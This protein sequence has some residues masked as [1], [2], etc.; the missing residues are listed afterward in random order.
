MRNKVNELKMGSTLFW[1]LSIGLKCSKSLRKS[2]SNYRQWLHKIGIGYPCH[3]CL[4]V[5]PKWISINSSSIFHLFIVFLSYFVPLFLYVCGFSITFIDWP[6]LAP[7]PLFLHLFRNHR[8]FAAAPQVAIVNLLFVGSRER[9]VL[10]QL[11]NYCVNKFQI[12]WGSNSRKSVLFM[13]SLAPPPLPP[14]LPKAIH[15]H[16]C[17]LWAIFRPKKPRNQR[18]SEKNGWRKNRE[19]R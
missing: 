15:I 7:P 8:S 13:N 5:T 14:L 2:I 4:Y 3:N 10:I 17:T 6:G 11:A 1:Q 9:F 12:A 18:D 16:F 19:K